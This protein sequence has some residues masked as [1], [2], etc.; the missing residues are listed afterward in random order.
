[1]SPLRPAAVAASL[2]RAARF[3]APLAAG[4]L[5]AA[6]AAKPVGSPQVFSWKL[7]PEPAAVA[8]AEALP[9]ELE[10]DDTTLPWSQKHDGPAVSASEPVRYSAVADDATVVPAGDGDGYPVALSP[11]EAGVAPEPVKETGLRYSSNPNGPRCTRD[12]AGWRCWR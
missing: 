5:A 9:V 7:A 2:I 1:M 6:C 3:T 8:A 11:E 10:A 4:L 12:H